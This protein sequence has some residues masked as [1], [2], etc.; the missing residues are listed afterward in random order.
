[1]FKSLFNPTSIFNELLESSER[2][3]SIKVRQYKKINQKLS[4]YSA[5]YMRRDISIVTSFHGITVISIANDEISHTMYNALIQKKDDWKEFDSLKFVTINSLEKV[6]YIICNSSFFY[7]FSSETNDILSLTDTFCN[8]LSTDENRIYMDYERFFDL[9]F[10][11]LEKP[12][13]SLFNSICS[14]PKNY[15]LESII[16]HITDYHASLSIHTLKEYLNDPNLLTKYDI[17][18]M[19]FILSLKS[20]LYLGS[21]SFAKAYETSSIS[22]S[23][24]MNII[25]YL[26][27]KDSIPDIHALFTFNENFDKYTISDNIIFDKKV[28]SSCLRH[29]QENSQFVM[30]QYYPKTLLFGH[31]TYQVAKLKDSSFGDNLSD[32]YIHLSN[33]HLLTKPKL[34]YSASSDVYVFNYK[35]GLYNIK[36]WIGCH[37]SEFT[38]FLY[39]LCKNLNSLRNKYNM[40]LLDGTD[41]LECISYHENLSDNDCFDFDLSKLCL[42]SNDNNKIAF[43]KTLVV[44]MAIGEYVKCNSIKIEDIY[45]CEFMKIFPSTF[46][47]VITDYLSTGEYTNCKLPKKLFSK[48]QIELF[49]F[50]SNIR[51][52]DNNYVSKISLFSDAKPMEELARA[53]NEQNVINRSK[54]YACL[55]EQLKHIDKTNRTLTSTNI[56]ILFETNNIPNLLTPEKVIISKDEITADNHYNIIG[57]VWNLSR[58][59]YKLKDLANSIS[60][61]SVYHYIGFLLQYWDSSKFSIAKIDE[62]IPELYAGRVANSDIYFPYIGRNSL[63]TYPFVKSKYHDNANLLKYYDEVVS[64]IEQI[65]PGLSSLNFEDIVP[66]YEY[67]PL[68]FNIAQFRD[69]VSKLREC[70]VHHQW[71]L[72]GDMCKECKMI[73]RKAPHFDISDYQIVYEDELATFYK[74]DF[75][76][77]IYR[78]NNLLL[79]K[80]L[81]VL[82]SDSQDVIDFFGNV[83]NAIEHNLYNKFTGLIPKKLIVD[84]VNSQLQTVHFGVE[85]DECNFENAMKLESFKHIQRLKVILVL[86][87]KLLPYI[88]DKSF[89]C[90]NSTIFRTMIMHKEHKGEILIPHL[91]LLQSDVIMGDDESSKEAL[92]SKTLEL[93]TNFLLDYINSDEFL[94]EL[95]TNSDACLINIVEDIKQQTFSS[96]LIEICLSQ[97][98]NYCLTHSLPFSN[99]SKFCPMCLK[100]GVTEENVIFKDKTYFDDLEERNPNFDGGEANIYSYTHN[101]V[102]KIFKNDV[103]L[104]FK[105]K[106]LCKSLEKL[107]LIEEF[108]EKYDDIEIIPVK[109]LLYMVDGNK[110]K[111]KGFTEEFVADSFKISSLKDKEF[112]KQHGYNRINVVEIL[113]KVCIGIEFLHSIGGF[114]GDLNG[115]NVLIKGNKVY[116]I[117]ID[118]MSFDD[119]QNCVY[120]N[121]YIYPPSAQN[122]NI[123]AKDDWYSLAVQAFYYLTY[124]HPFRGICNNLA[125][126]ENETSR[127][128]FG[129][130]VLGNH[131]ITPP[132]ISIGWDFFTKPLF[133]YFIKTFEGDKR[134]SMLTVL[135]DYY[136]HLENNELKFVEIAHKHSVSINISEHTYIDSD[137]K[138][139]FK[140]QV[141]ADVAGC[142]SVALKNQ[143]VLVALANCSYLLN[144]ET[145]NLYKANKSYLDVPMDICNGNV[146]Y[147][148]P[149]N[150]TLLFDDEAAMNG[151][152][153]SHI[154]RKTTNDPI[155]A[156]C[157]TETDKFVFV[158][159]NDFA[160]SYD[161]YCNSIKTHCISK[162]R[163]EGHVSI[164]IRFDEI[165]KKWLVLFSDSSISLGVIID[166]ESDVSSHF[167]LK[168]SLSLSVCFY[169]NVL[170]YVDNGKICF[171]NINS[172][173]LKNF[174]S[175]YVTK[176]SV[177]QRQGNKFIIINGN[178]AYMYTKS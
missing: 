160:N 138:L 90:T 135:Q 112:V 58:P 123:T 12:L 23:L 20:G 80:K 53:V 56:D 101:E 89:I 35:P 62:C 55:D 115:G 24:L 99:D 128:E 27:D 119:V 136:T 76:P 131:N 19:L 144:Q 69:N 172:K 171:Y 37:A 127:M 1:M 104:S 84:D 155:K 15:S 74:S 78:P 67:V 103:D 137:N 108:N 68:S 85:Y 132:S 30:Y 152:G 33:C 34:V 31:G 96:E 150:R 63:K 124:S 173:K 42:D 156:L 10:F 162:S 140:E 18:T 125:V 51:L 94:C 113:I 109:N 77:I 22:T 95:I 29:P 129:F 145:G 126:P 79:C 142:H 87:Q 60:H 178:K 41:L 177:I 121:M 70:S 52:Y 14:E 6:V 36:E 16:S 88:L 164:R 28:F 117:D 122:N 83:K 48:E 61:K 149:D 167:E 86:Y 157:V 105:S 3:K 46:A 50:D 139:V 111:L 106:I 141:L 175:K 163:F 91:P 32:I 107:K 47:K 176:K 82:S 57:V 7:D 146:Y 5:Y 39:R 72:Y 165:S 154:I 133:E 43:D 118:G 21:N 92:A 168:E 65:F 17:D 81:S 148:S 151:S 9:R 100:D 159:D 73:Y 75:S 147:T 66:D 4:D 97:Y 161:I 153:N 143:I 114:I 54:G 169:G 11:H 158:E 134:E 64:I 116:I 166:R 120:T 102:Q 25:K 110:I 45:S 8:L 49:E 93:F 2:Y 130:S 71:Y 26:I 174:D 40:F 170:Y 38:V 13:Y 98:K 59:I 44:L